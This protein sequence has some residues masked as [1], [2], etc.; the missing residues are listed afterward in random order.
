MSTSVEIFEYQQREGEHPT[1]A[2]FFLYNDSWIAVWLQPNADG[3]IEPRAVYHALPVRR[4]ELG[5]V[6]LS[7]DEVQAAI[8]AAD[9]QHYLNQI[10]HRYQARLER[11]EAGRP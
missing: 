2:L 8:E 1:R 7:V 3:V 5:N 11:Q 4:R 10:V 6:D 9:A